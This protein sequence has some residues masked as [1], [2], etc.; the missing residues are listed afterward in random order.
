[1]RIALPTDDGVSI[2]AHF[3]RSAQFLIFQVEDGRVQS[4]ELKPNAGQHTSHAA[5]GCQS[6]GSGHDHGLI[7]SSLTGCDAVIC[8]GMSARAA[9]ALKLNGVKEI[10]M[11]EPGPAAGAVNAYLAGTLV[12]RGPGFCHCS[13]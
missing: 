6:G 4:Q 2:A 7:V 5:G 8:T 10:I 11:T 1:M 13:H 3:G 12:S 9:E